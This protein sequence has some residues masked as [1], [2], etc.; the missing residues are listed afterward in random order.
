VL[1]DGFQQDSRLADVVLHSEAPL[2]VET[3]QDFLSQRDFFK[4]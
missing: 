4:Y 1:E 3:F 2:A